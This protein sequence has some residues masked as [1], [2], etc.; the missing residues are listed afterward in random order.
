MF[1]T[2]RR[3]IGYT[4]STL[5][6]GGYT[7]HPYFAPFRAS[8]RRGIARRICKFLT[9]D[10]IY[11]RIP[12]AANSTIVRTIHTAENINPGKQVTDARAI[13]ELKEMYNT[14]PSQSEFDR[15]FKFTFVRNPHT[16]ALSAYRERVLSGRYADK[17]HMRLFYKGSEPVSFLEFLSI[18]EDG[19]LYE[20][21]H[22][23]PQSDL[24]RTDRLDFVGKIESLDADLTSVLERL[25]F[26]DRRIVSFSPHAT[27]SSSTPLATVEKRRVERLYQRDFDAFSY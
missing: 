21:P 7:N 9:R 25:K 1:K 5:R 10:A 23:A 3:L 14:I 16:R 12:K 26:E 11:F 24:V 20:D 19:H 13:D 8:L 22:W 6:Y 15:C 17:E 2:R 27:N 18:L 4:V